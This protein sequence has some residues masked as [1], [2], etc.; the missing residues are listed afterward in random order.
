MRP[1]A[2]V[3]SLK[4]FVRADEIRNTAFPGE[5]DRGPAVIER[6]KASDDTARLSAS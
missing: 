2:T 5:V 3:V 6:A 1:S 4:A